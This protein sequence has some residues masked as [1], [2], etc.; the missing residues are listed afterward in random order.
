MIPL[1]L[2]AL[3][4]VQAPQAAKAEKAPI[5]LARAVPKDALFFVQLKG[6]ES[7]RA[8][9]E[10][11]SWYGFYQDEDMKG[12]RGWIAKAI[13][14]KGG[15][16]KEG[17][18]DI[19]PWAFLQS[20]HGSVALFGVVQ[21]TVKEPSIGIL[22]DP[23]E[24]RAAFDGMLTKIAEYWKKKRTASGEDYSGVAM[25]VIQ[26]AP[27]AE[28]DAPAQDAK[29]FTAL[30]DVSGATCIVLADSREELIGTAH[31]IVD[32][33]RAKDSAAGIDGSALLAEARASAAKPGRFEAFGD[34]SKLTEAARTKAAKD[35]KNSKV[36][37]ALGV[38]GL[39]WLY[40]TGDVGKGE[41][42]SFDVTAKIPEKGYLHDWA[43]L[44]GKVSRDLAGK[45]PRESA[46]I[47]LYQFDVWGL[48]QS[49][50]KLYAEIDSAAAAKAKEAMD[51][52]L[53]QYSAG[54]LE[55]DFIAQ[56][57]GRFLSFEVP[58]PAAESSAAGKPAAAGLGSATLIGLQDAQVVSE[59]LDEIVKGI[60]MSE[61]VKTED[62]QGTKVHAFSM[63]PGV[64]MQWAFT[65]NAM[66]L[67]QLPT[68]MHEAVRM[69][70]AEKKDSALEK[71]VFKPLFDAH[72]DASALSLAATPEV[73]K[74]TLAAFKQMSGMLAQAT[75]GADSPLRFL[76]G[77]ES[78]D[79]HFKG[80]M[81]SC[82]TRSGS[83][84]HLQFFS[85]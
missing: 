19:D 5:V 56:F 66:I 82:L 7:L 37:D 49:A 3:L 14:D 21:S 15:D 11:G 35:E 41:T 68:A 55:K 79:R 80:T 42:V 51:S 13:A 67:A 33:F 8:D 73:F 31:G 6:L 57:D 74:M 77:P 29:E 60:G 46:A 52:G 4:S 36:L 40:A 65:K 22:I 78:V 25:Q 20:V 48:W 50:W 69:Q 28:G 72:A 26:K 76:P 9:F 70:S 59:F 84:L 2:A 10:A 61:M 23:G 1:M 63:G 30:F 16:K 12:L 85:R 54:D 17:A 71:D 27:A 24:P 58:V 32:R 83:V 43:G 39:R 45:A 64:S 62:Y 18:L 34:L 38:D 81:V 75:G 44:L 53:E 47:A